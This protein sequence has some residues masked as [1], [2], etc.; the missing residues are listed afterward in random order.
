MKILVWLI[1]ALNVFLGLRCFLNVIGV[2][3]TSKYAPSTTVI[4]AVIFLGLGALGF[5]FTLF[6][7]E[8]KLALLI[9]FGPWLLGIV[10]LFLTMVFSKHQ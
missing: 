6:R 3:H 10:V 1:S 8:P 7:S 5:Y 2:L 4:F 9:A